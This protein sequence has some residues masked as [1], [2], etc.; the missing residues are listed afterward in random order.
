MP[1]QDSILAV[2]VVLH[3]DPEVSRDEWALLSLVDGRRRVRDLV[4]LTGAGQFAVTTTLAHLVQRGLLHVRDAAQPDHVTIVERRLAMLVGRRVGRTGDGGR[5]PRSG[6]CA[7]AARSRDPGRPR[8]S[9]DDALQPRWPLPGRPRASLSRV[10]PG[11]ARSRVRQPAAR[12]SRR[13]PSPSFPAVVPSTPSTPS[14]RRAC[15]APSSVSGGSVRPRVE[16]ATARSL[17]EPEPGRRR[18]GRR[19]RHRT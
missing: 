15:R 3:H 14:R 10:S 12:S 1:S 17:H 11:P 16:G 18:D 7:A 9:R 5:S 19:G 2:P 6:A 4:E 13:A 8:L